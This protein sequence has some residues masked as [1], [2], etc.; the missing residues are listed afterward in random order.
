MRALKQRTQEPNFSGNERLKECRKSQWFTF[1]CYMT[2]KYCLIITAQ[3]NTPFTVKEIEAERCPSHC[4]QPSGKSE[5]HPSLSSAS[6]DQGSLAAHIWRTIS[7]NPL[8]LLTSQSFISDRWQRWWSDLYSVTPGPP[9][10]PQCSYP[11]A[12][13]CKAFKVFQCPIMSGC[14]AGKESQF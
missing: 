8:G 11:Q 13:F 5:L 10:P 4:H 2:L 9:L 6:K 7:I 12:C 1:P 3:R 14:Q